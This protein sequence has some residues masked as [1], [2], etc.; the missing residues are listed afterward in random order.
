[1]AHGVNVTHTEGPGQAIKPI[2]FIRLIESLTTMENEA[3][4]AGSP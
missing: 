3:R 2:D 4:A 1:M